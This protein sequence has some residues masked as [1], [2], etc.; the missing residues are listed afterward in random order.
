MS[1]IPLFDLTADGKFRLA[2]DKLQWILQKRVLRGGRLKG[3]VD[4]KPGYRGLW[5][6]G[7]K[8]TTLQEG[9]ERWHVDLTPEARRRFYALPR[10]FDE[11]HDQVSRAD[12]GSPKSDAIKPVEGDAQC[13]LGPEG[14]LPLSNG[15]TARAPASNGEGPETPDRAP[16]P[17]RTTGEA[18]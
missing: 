12:L 9:F 11:F 16:G 2:Y 1:N 15:G 17:D 5:F 4:G 3:V 14:T 10:T 18:A 13:D 8:K 6:V 7:R